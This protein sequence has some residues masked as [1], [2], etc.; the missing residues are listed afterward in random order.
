VLKQSAILIYLLAIAMIGS[1]LQVH[2]QSDTLKENKID[3]LL[4]RQ[5][6]LLGQLAQGLMTDVDVEEDKPI[7]RNDEPFRK[8][9]KKI[10]RRIA[11]LSLNFGE[12][13]NDTAQR[14]ENGLTKLANT[15]HKNSR[16]FVIRNHL[17]FKEHDRLSSYLMGN[18]ERYLR[19]LPF[20]QEAHILVKR[21]RSSP[22][23]VD[24][25]VVTKDVLSIGGGIDFKS[26]NSV[27]LDF[28]EDN[29]GGWGD[30]LEL[31]ALI[32]NTRK[33]TL[34]LG[35]EYLKRNIM[36]TFIDGNFGYLNF[37][38]TFSSG[39]AEEKVGFLRLTKPLV[40][41]YMDWTYSVNAELHSTSN[42]FNN[43][44]IYQNAYKYK[45]RIYDTW[46]VRNLSSSHKEVD[47]EYKRLRWLI[48]GRVMD[49]KFLRKPMEYTSHYN[50]S[51]AD[52]T[53][54]LGS[55]SIYKLN[56]YK[57]SYVYGFG[58]KE[59]L[60]EGLEATVTGGWTKK[61]GRER[62]YLGLAFQRYYLGTREGY[63]NYS[64]NIGTSF[65]QKKLQDLN[66]LTNIDYFTRLRQINKK[67]KQRAF[68]NA[69]FGRLVNG[70]LDEPLFLESKYGLD[71]FSNNS[72]GGFLRATV[73]AESIFFSPWTLLY[74]RF[75]PFVFS[76]ATL[77]RL[78]EANGPNT[79]F[80][81]AIGGGMRIRNESLIFG[82]IE[83]RGVYFPKKD[84]SGNSYGIQLNTNLRYKYNQNF[85]RKPDFVQVN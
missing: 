15:F 82:T 50:Y 9:E 58:R 30:R 46:A 4:M 1:C 66:L 55:V 33:H 61:E 51:F 26:S 64:I 79:R 43:D 84:A 74:F 28:K 48:G 52:V 25:M 21:V 62:P 45:Y 3:S 8:Y 71:Q 10:I 29:F 76:S 2:A 63:F 73:K 19:D 42:M 57:T 36:G 83:L 38:N 39:R 16:A 20:L 56:F 40:N 35:A 44:S 69:S 24:V 18:N 23:S 75:A 85:I 37:N 53:A 27:K 54:I 7:Q 81:P 11:V 13:L 70:S 72:A 41:P 68:L 6:G 34:G 60:P 49:Q 47:R 32:D 5:K 14:Q 77:F 12:Y 22:D 59:D 67:W 80:Y 65:Y 17:F 78:N 31:E